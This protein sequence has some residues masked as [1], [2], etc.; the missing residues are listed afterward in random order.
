MSRCSR[1]DICFAAHRVTRRMH[2]P[3]EEDW[4]LAKRIA[5]YLQG[6]KHM[7]LSM[8]DDNLLSKDIGIVG[9]SDAD[10]ASHRLVRKS[11]T[12]GWIIADGMPVLWFTKNQG[13]VSL[14][15]MEAEFTSASAV[16]RPNARISRVNSTNWLV[17]QEAYIFACRQSGGAE[18]A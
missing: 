17:V 9:Y 10:F 1:P 8:N 12:G 11:V 16:G 5:R 6:T 2:S 4:K 18:S 13:G 14:S 7:R 3:T 15:T